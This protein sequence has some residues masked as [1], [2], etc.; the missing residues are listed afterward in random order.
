VICPDH[1]SY[2][3]VAATGHGQDRVFVLHQDLVNLCPTFGGQALIAHH[4][5]NLGVALQQ[6]EGDPIARVGCGDAIGHQGMDFVQHLAVIVADLGHVGPV[7]DLAPCQPIHGFH[8]L[9]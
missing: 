9:V 2:P 8:Q 4:G 1:A 5:R 3:I 7:G 6:L